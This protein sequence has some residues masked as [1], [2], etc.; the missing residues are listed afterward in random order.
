MKR[1]FVFEVQDGS[2]VLRG[3]RRHTKVMSL[4]A[5]KRYLL[6]PPSVVTPKVWVTGEFVDVK[7]SSVRFKGLN[8]Y[9]DT[10]LRLTRDSDG[11][12]PFPA[13]ELLGS[14]KFVETTH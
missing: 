14:D 1:G 2:G 6:V 5:G 8:G 9:P 7:G 10:I 11:Y 4:R 12:Y 13:K 3:V